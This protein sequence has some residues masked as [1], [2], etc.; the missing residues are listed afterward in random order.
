MQL[1]F[2]YPKKDGDVEIKYYCPISLV[3]GVCKIISKVLANVLKTVLEKVI[4]RSHNEFI[5]G[6]QILN[7]VLVANQ[8]LDRRIRLRKPNMIA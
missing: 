6:R 5:R 7:Y 2:P 8:C 3:G 1:Y 4:S